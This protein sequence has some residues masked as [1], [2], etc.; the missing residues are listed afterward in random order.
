MEDNKGIVLLGYEQK[1]ILFNAL[2]VD[3]IQFLESSIIKIKMAHLELCSLRNIKSSIKD[4][5]KQW[6]NELIKKG[7]TNNFPECNFEYFSN[8]IPD[9]IAL[10]KV[11]SNSLNY[12][13]SFFDNFAQFLNVTLLANEAIE[14]NSV[15]IKSL[16]NYLKSKGI[17]K[18]ISDKI[19][20]CLD[21]STYKF[22]EAYN[23]ITKHQINIFVDSRLFLNNGEL[24]TNIPEIKKKRG[25]VEEVHLS[26]DLE[27]KI[28]ESYE[29]V[30]NFCSTMTQEVYGM[31]MK[32][33]HPYTENRHHSVNTRI[34][35]ANPQKNVMRATEVYIVTNEKIK[36]DD[37]YYFLFSKDDEDEILLNNCTY[38]SIIIKD[39]SNKIVGMLLADDPNISDDSADKVIFYQYRKYIVNVK[40]YSAALIDHIK[41]TD[42][43]SA[44]Y[45]DTTFISIPDDIEKVPPSIT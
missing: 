8:R 20:K 29:F 21:D 3:G 24:E 44:G 33:S 37:Q 30:K 45:G 28:L 32:Q 27:T 5:F 6:K 40:N 2:V 12:L 4:S 19:D 17:Y 23:N 10:Y 35:L 18:E 22:I 9:D 25:K 14:R 41:N 1:R 34:Q 16:N 36:Q 7:S 39:S 38:K 31:L 42:K 43:I 26:S 11:T 15:S 13:H